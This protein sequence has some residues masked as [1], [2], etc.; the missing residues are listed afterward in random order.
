MADAA[1]STFPGSK[2]SSVPSLAINGRIVRKRVH[3]K[4]HYVQLM[5]PAPD[6]FTSPAQIEV[7]SARS[8][9]DVGDD[10]S[11]RL[12]VGGYKRRSYN[13]TDRETGESRMVHPVENTL[14]VLD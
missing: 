11:I 9:G 5:L 8:L 7:R 10:V 13:Y 3:D 14:S 1:L 12:T 2:S 4:V 6:E